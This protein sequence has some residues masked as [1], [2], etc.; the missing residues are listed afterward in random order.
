MR[1]L[2]IKNDENSGVHMPGIGFRPGSDSL[3]LST[4]VVMV[5]CTNGTEIVF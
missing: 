5:W 2:E 3:I 1:F 4:P